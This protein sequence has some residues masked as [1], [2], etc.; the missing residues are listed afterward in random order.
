M[1]IDSRIAQ[2]IVE[3]L[4]NIIRHDINFFS[5]DGV[6]IASTDPARIG[7]RHD[8]ARLAA[9]ERCT[10]AVD[11]DNQFEGARHGINAPV[12]LGD[13]VAAV[14]GITGERAEVEPFGE[15]IR[16]MTEI[17]IRENM[18]QITR[19]DRRMMAANLI[20]LLSAKD[21]DRG[22][23]EYLAT[24]LGLDMKAPHRM[25]VGRCT[26]Q[27][28]D[29]SGRDDIY[30]ILARHLS[31]RE[32]TVFAVSA[33]GFQLLLGERADKGN[34]DG[35]GNG[36]HADGA[37]S[38]DDVTTPDDGQSPH[39]TLEAI[40]RD[41]EQAL[42]RPIS[43]DIGER[44]PTAD[45]CWLSYSQA[46][47]TV[48]WLR[49]TGQARVADYDS[50]GLGIVASAVDRDAAQRFVAQVFAG[51]SERDIDRFRTTFEVYTRHNGSIN[52][53]AD[54]LFMHKNTLQ[55]HLNNMAKRTG[56]NPRDLADHDTLAM[57]FLLRGH[58]AF[59]AQ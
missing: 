46:R 30:D 9:T 49:F 36:G 16:K 56:Y 14:I 8:A 17:L 12:M 51:L 37:E 11:A 26:Q 42:D 23:V 47:T 1:N 45:R 59:R 38:S 27:D 48:D 41:I 39:D 7:S 32:N 40:R 52:R 53:A 19:F 28:A 33:Q 50:I 6:M 57:A 4:K 35:D 44:A 43:I 24:T 22:L 58:L 21:H 20:G 31:D 15:V 13:D 54:E 10:I 34:A 29:H 2:T 18:D 5:P 25:A 55:N 3:N